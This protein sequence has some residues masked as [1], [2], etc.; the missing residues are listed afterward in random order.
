MKR[1]RYLIEAAL[2][3]SLIFIFGKMSPERASAT[4]GAIL[5]FIGPKLSSSR[6]AARHIKRSLHTPPEKTREIVLGMWENLGRVFA[7]YPHLPELYAHH[8]E[9]VGLE[10]V[11]ELIG[12]D[13]PAIF[14]SGHLANWELAGPSIRKH[15]MNIDLVYRKPNNPYV[16]G[17][18]QHCRSMDE[19]LRTYSKSAQGMRQVIEALK[20]GR[21]IGILIDQKYNQGVAADFFGRTAMTSTA[22]IQLAKRFQCPLIPA[23]IERIDGINFRATIYPPMDISKDDD[24]LIR[25]AHDLLESWISERPEQWLWIHRRWREK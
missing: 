14:F 11:A 15:G 5:G 6:K 17:I 19:T 4:G 7:E 9:T 2:V 8:I 16:D 22:F 12:T 24:T 3:R 25:E 21:R 13:H 10:H 20:D 23:R 18:L 1:I